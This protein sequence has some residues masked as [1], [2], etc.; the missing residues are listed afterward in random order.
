MIGL[1]FGS[2]NP[3]GTPSQTAETSYQADG[4]QSRVQD[5]DSEP[6]VVRVAA[7]SPDH[8]TLVAAVKAAELLDVLSNVGPFTVFA[9]TNAAFEA[10]PAGTVEDLLKPANKAKLQDILQYHVT[11]SSLSTDYLSDGMTLSMANGG[12]AKI[13]VKDGK[14][15]IN[16]ANIVGSVKASN[17]MVHV[18]D[19]VILPQ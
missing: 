16:G 6:N 4:G 7:N 13:A 5:E 10:L 15:Q 14:Y 3:S 17:G 11:T 19:A 8:T 1:F 18:I 9:P 2:C 12:K